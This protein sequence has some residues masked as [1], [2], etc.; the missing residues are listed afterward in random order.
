MRHRFTFL[1]ILAMA[2]TAF[3]V[4]QR[5]QRTAIVEIRDSIIAAETALV[6]ARAD[7][8]YSAPIDVSKAKKVHFFVQMSAD[9]AFTADSST[10]EVQFTKGAG[11]ADW[12][13]IVD[14]VLAKWTPTA[15]IYTA[16]PSMVLNLDTLAATLG[17]IPDKMRF[18]FIHR[19]SVQVAD[20]AGMNGAGATT[21]VGETFVTKY[22]V[23]YKLWE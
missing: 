23:T 8:G 2:A 19:D 1:M 9:T 13:T 12:K 4:G 17:I 11:G 5:S 21:L 14:S 7:T 16:Y 22:M 20:T 6:F 10:I 3:G 15:A 18:R